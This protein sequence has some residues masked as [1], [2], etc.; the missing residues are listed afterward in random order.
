MRYEKPKWLG[1]VASAC[2]GVLAAGCGGA[3]PVPA[4][5][6]ET[7]V[8]AALIERARDLHA[9]VLTIDTHDDIPLDF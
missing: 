2:I 8:D 3:V 7:E 5:P 4:P 1:G 9:R 6:S